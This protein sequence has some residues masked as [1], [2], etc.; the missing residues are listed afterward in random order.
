[1]GSKSRSHVNKLSEADKRF[2][3]TV[4]QEAAK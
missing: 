4:K 1:M 3:L 2:L